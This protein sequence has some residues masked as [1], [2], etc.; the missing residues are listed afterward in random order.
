MQITELLSDDAIIKE[1]GHRLALY[2]LNRNLSQQ[3]IA[4]QAGTGVN[5][6]YRLESGKSTQLS[7]VIRICR[8]L[9]LAAN[10]DTLVPEPKPSPIE[11]AKLQREQ[12][13]RAR[14]SKKDKANA[15]PQQWHWGDEP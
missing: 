3:E 5:T 15:L 9:G 1:L 8:A 6:V 14:Q 2:R 10:F 11:Q 4:D 13:Q 7:S 12:R